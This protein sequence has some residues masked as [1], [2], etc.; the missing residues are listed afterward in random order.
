M[1]DRI[2]KSWITTGLGLN[3]GLFGLAT[4]WYGKTTIGETIPIWIVGAVFIA[5]KDS[6]ISGLVSFLPKVK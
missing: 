5:A 4:L 3:I 1:K 2:I 6:V